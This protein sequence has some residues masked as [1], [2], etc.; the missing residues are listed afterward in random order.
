MYVS[1]PIPAEHWRSHRPVPRPSLATERPTLEPA[2]Q[3]RNKSSPTEIAA[4]PVVCHNYDQLSDHHYAAPTA[5]STP[6]E[7]PAAQGLELQRESQLR[8]RRDVTVYTAHARPV[9]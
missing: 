4:G 1:P 2:Q 8:S 7:F 6:S 5:K 9:Q 3:D